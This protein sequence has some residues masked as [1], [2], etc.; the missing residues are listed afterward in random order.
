MFFF[1]PSPYQLIEKNLSTA[2][3][4]EGNG[5]TMRL[6]ALQ[7]SSHNSWQPVGDSKASTA[8][9]QLKVASKQLKASPK[10]MGGTLIPHIQNFYPHTQF[11]AQF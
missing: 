11:L 6:L 1:A 3:S 8:Q 10:Q 7:T 2:V 5:Q 9:A 4:S